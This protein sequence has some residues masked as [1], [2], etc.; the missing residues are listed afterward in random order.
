[1]SEI[2]SQSP[3][4][5]T[6]FFIDLK[7]S[8]R[9]ETTIVYVPVGCFLVVANDSDSR[10][11]LGIAHYGNNT[12]FTNTCNDTQCIM[13]TRTVFGLCPVAN[14]TAAYIGYATPT[15]G[16]L[17]FPNNFSIIFSPNTTFTAAITLLYNSTGQ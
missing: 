10:I 3:D 11:S 5:R 16:H 4:Q 7:L 8:L 15:S 1:M 2:K 12:I 6:V 17:Q 14:V 13:Q 9:D